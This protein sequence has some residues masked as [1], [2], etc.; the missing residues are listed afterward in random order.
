MIDELIAGHHPVVSGELH[1]QAVD[2]CRETH[3]SCRRIDTD[4]LAGVDTVAD[5]ALGQS[6]RLLVELLA[7]LAHH[8][9]A[10]CFAPP[11]DP[12]HPLDIAAALGHV[13]VDD[14]VELSYRTGRRLD[15]GLHLGHVLAR[16][17]RERLG[18]QLLLRVE[19]VV[20]EAAGH[21]EPLGHVG[22]ARGREAALDDHLARDLEDL[23]TP[24]CDRGLLHRAHDTGDA[25]GW[26]R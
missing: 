21:A 17:V 14:P 7:D 12:Q 3:R 18:E 15:L 13:V 22:D 8:R 25:G 4:E 10:Q 2:H 16:V 6:S 23:R 19:V 1:R 5:D 24:F 9:V 11:V 26:T 20:D